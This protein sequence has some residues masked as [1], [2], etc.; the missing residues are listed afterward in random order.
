M[1]RESIIILWVAR[2]FAEIDAAQRSPIFNQ[3]KCKDLPAGASQE[4]AIVYR[5]LYQTPATLA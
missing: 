4:P 3:L 5:R 1:C 2:W